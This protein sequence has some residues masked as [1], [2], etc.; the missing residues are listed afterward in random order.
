MMSQ[1]DDKSAELSHAQGEIERLERELGGLSG[2]REAATGLQERNLE[3]E[4]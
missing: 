3:L 4:R 2:S 1:L